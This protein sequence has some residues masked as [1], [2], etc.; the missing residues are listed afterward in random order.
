MLSLRATGFAALLGCLACAGAP[1]EGVSRLVEYRSPLDDS[2]QAYGVYLPGSPPPSEQGYPAVLHGHGYGW[3]VSTS[4]S[5]FQRQW[6]DEHGWVMIHLNARGPNFYEGVGDLETLRVVDDA[7]AR[8]GI[9]RDRVYMTGGSMGG[10]GALRH[11]LRHPDVFAA[12]M[13]VDGWTD[14]RLWHHHWYART[15]YRDLIEEFRRPLLEAASPLYWAE[16][17]RWG[18]VGHIVDGSD[19][20]V[21][22]EN[23]LRLR[24]RLW[25][26]SAKQP[27]AYDY[28]LIFN[29]TLGHGGGTDYRAIYGFFVGRR[30]IRWPAGFTVQ[31]TVLPHAQLYWGRIEDLLIDGLSGQ[32][33]AYAEGDAVAV[34]TE[35]LRAF[36]LHLAASPSAAEGW[37]RVY[38]DGFPCYEG[39]PGTISL[40]ADVDAAGMVIGWHRRPRMNALRKH[41]DLCGPVG[42]AFLSPFVVAWATAGGADE[43]ARH[44][45]E[46]EQFAESWNGF[47]VHAEAVE[48][49]PEDGI[50]PADLA[51]HTIVL[52]GSIDSSRLLRRAHAA[53][54]FPVEVRD[55]GVIVHDPQHGD[56]RYLGEKFGALMCYPNPLT[57]FSTYLVIANRRMYMKPDGG[58]PQLLGYDLEKLPWAY[59]DYLVFN[60]DQSELPFVLNVNNKPPVTCYEAAYFVEAGFFDDA[61]RIDRGHQL[62]RVLVQEPEHHRLIHVAELTLSEASGRPA[63]RV[64]V[65]DA[66]GA[67]VHTARVTGRW[68][69]DGEAVA[70]AST[71]EDG[72]AQFACPPGVAPDV[73]G[74]Q[75]VNVMATG[76]TYDWTADVGRCLAAGWGS[77]RQLELT[78]VTDEPSVAP[79]D[80]LNLRLAVSNA[81][82]TAREVEVTVA[83][84]SGTVIPR[85]RR[86]SVGPHGRADAEFTWRP[87]GRRPGP[88]M[89]RA[90]ATARGTVPAH[91]AL[92]IEVAVLPGPRLPVV[93][94]EVSAA[95][96][97]WGKPWKVSAT[98]RS[99]GCEEPVEATVHCALLEAR[100]FPAAKSVQVPAGEAV[101]VQW[102]GEETIGKGEHTVRV[103]VEGVAGATATDSFA[104]R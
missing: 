102:A 95:D 25:E 92:P 48:A 63:A 29:P 15:D 91:A 59:P 47:M 3:R 11:G 9:D 100:G 82:G 44:R 61:W 98:L 5:G 104:V 30:R 27:G 49:V 26:L 41:P 90:E 4:F 53:H 37:V 56:R 38:A 45:L 52:F 19:T 31:S 85:W 7:A 55:D 77:P 18:A 28:R 76:C 24:Q 103:S 58:S 39:F 6:A 66:G 12:V 46:A 65:T 14:F 99:W 17:G 72:R 54:P 64:R 97:E 68:W 75:V 40:E 78:L 88:A 22:P 36:T 16:R 21:L 1:A 79:E 93:V 2:I 35:N 101:T 10:T 86:V 42:H 87:E 50:D 80:A 43:V 33:E 32:L 8:F 81:A 71:D 84:P 74:F 83:A 67:P 60:N 13:G 20:T 70:S 34:R 23:G 62:R 69:A 96:I 89:L 51:S 57:D 73:A 94:T